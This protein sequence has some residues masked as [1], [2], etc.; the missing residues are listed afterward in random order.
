MCGVPARTSCVRGHAAISPRPF[1]L[2]LW[3]MALVDYSQLPI[4]SVRY[5]PAHHPDLGVQGRCQPCYPD[6]NNLVQLHP[7]DR[8]HWQLCRLLV[9]LT[10]AYLHRASLLDQHYVPSTYNGH[11]AFLEQW[12][13]K[14]R[15]SLQDRLDYLAESYANSVRAVTIQAAWTD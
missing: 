10:K 14:I 4:M 7:S 8:R 6:L 12:Y 11:G 1:P 15:Q 5:G 13:A 2:L 3:H 9:Q